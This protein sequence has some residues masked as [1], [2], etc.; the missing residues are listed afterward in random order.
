[1]TVTVNIKDKLQECPSDPNTFSS[2]KQ[3]NWMNLFH[4]SIGYIDYRV[5]TRLKP[6]CLGTLS[7]WMWTL[8]AP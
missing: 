6:L 1:M 4:K 3:V 8:L 7:Y 2:K 5:G